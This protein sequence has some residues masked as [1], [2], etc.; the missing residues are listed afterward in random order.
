MT[1]AEVDEINNDASVLM[2]RG[3]ALMEEPRREAAIDA[4][5]CFDEA[6]VLRRRVPADH[7]PFQGYLLAACLLN[8]GDA[9]VRM[10]DVG[11]MAAALASYEEGIEV[12][13]ALPLADDSRYPR[14]LA[15]AL[16]NRGLA[17][18]ARGRRRRR[19]S[20]GRRVRRGRRRA[21]S[22]ILGAASR[23]ATTCARW[24]G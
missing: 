18:Q 8:R 11:P 15:M 23:T 16:Q 14:R 6:L 21:R 2:K 9:L 17:L 10:N 24:C 1:D 5:H 7:S 3:I 22:R 13:R 12:L 19:R 20:G 4:L